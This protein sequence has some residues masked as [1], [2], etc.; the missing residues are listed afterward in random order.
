MKQ[1]QLF[2]EWNS[3]CDKLKILSSFIQN[4]FTKMLSDNYTNK[5]DIKKTVMEFNNLYIKRISEISELKTKI[6]FQL[7][8][9]ID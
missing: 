8:K 2:N 6:E 7:H 3:S 1:E 9:Y 5:E 4:D